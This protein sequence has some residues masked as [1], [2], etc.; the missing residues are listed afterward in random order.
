MI[1]GA[2]GA[3]FICSDL[4]LVVVRFLA[5]VRDQISSN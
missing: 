4:D 2:R 3:P 1:N 5:V